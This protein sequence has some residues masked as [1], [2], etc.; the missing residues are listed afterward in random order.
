MSDDKPII[1]MKR[2]EYQ[3]WYYKHRYNNDESFKM[4]ELERKHMKYI[5]DSE[6]SLCSVCMNDGVST[7]FIP[8]GHTFCTV[9]SNKTIHS[10]YFCRAKIQSKLKLYFC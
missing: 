8:C 1:N 10:C 2:K 5:N 4:K 7:A 3:K 9:C 6:F